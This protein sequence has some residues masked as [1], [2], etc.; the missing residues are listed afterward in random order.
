MTTGHRRALSSALSLAALAGLATAQLWPGLSQDLSP[1]ISWDHGSHLGKAMLTAQELLPW[2]LRGW[3]DLV[4]TGVPLGTLYTPIGTM[5]ILLFRAVTP[6]LEW[7][8]SY[9][10][11]FLGFRVLVG[12]SVYR[13]ARVAGAGHLGATA[14]GV[15]AL[16]D[17]GDHSEG[18]WFYDVL[19]GV[20]PMSIAMCF[21][22]LALAD[23]LVY[24]E[25]GERVVG[26]RAALLL[27]VALFS[28]QM[29]LVAFGLVVPCLVVAR[30]TSGERTSLRTDLS[31]VLPVA[32]VGGAIASWWM[33]PMLSMSRWLEDHG[34]LYRDT[35]DMGA[36]LLGGEGILGAGAWTNVLVALGLAAALV[37]KSA[38]R[39]LALGALVA[40]LVG[41]SGWFLAL[42]ASRYLPAFGRIV[43]PRLMMVSKPMLFALAGVV[44]H[45]LGARVLPVLRAQAR[46]PR[47]RLGLVVAALALAPFL[48]DVPARLSTLLLERDVPTTAT[49]SAWRDFRAAW[50]WV[51][52]RPDGEGF[53]RVA[54][55][56]ESTHLPQAAP[57]YTGRPAH[58]TGPLVG[59]SFRNNTDS[60]HPLALRAMNVRYVVTEGAPGLELA[61]EVDRVATFGGLV[62]SELRGWSGAVA[63]AGEGET[64]VPRTVALERERVVVEPHGARTVVVRR[65]L[66]PGWVATADGTEVP[67]GEERVFDSPRL[68]LMRVEVPAGTERLELRYHGFRAPHWL[69]MLATLVG[70]LVTLLWAGGW[71]RVPAPWRA[72]AAALVTRFGA[73]VP[74]SLERAWPTLACALPFVG[75]AALVLANARGTHLPPR[76]R[77]A[78]GSV[79]HDD[80]TTTPCARR[81]SDGALRCDE[82]VVERTQVAVDGVYRSCLTAPPPRGGTLVLAWDDLLLGGTLRLGGGV[83]D[84]A[85]LRRGAPIEV[86]A[87][88]DGDEVTTFEVPLSHE[89]VERTVPV[90]GGGGTHDVR[91]EVRSDETHRRLFCL[92]A[93][94]R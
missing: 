58:I 26:A 54:Y 83:D 85:F 80:G 40:M 44:L 9:A 34:Q 10:L 53:Y 61:S 91:I 49:T 3:T 7:H 56:S 42:D 77:E 79:L 41:A 24:V 52:D 20:W 19:Y 30:M 2:S 14:A 84:Q 33:L 35:P 23:L 27:G 50:A 47:G 13:L 93:V 81:S 67:I 76:L 32:F 92:D 75:V 22:F 69:G 71:E 68:R 18:G 25:K 31:R 1:P 90:P 73:R 63:V 8:Q 36:R 45:E 62:L 37:G 70:L 60:T 87:L 16:A 51:A 65:A 38:R 82:V 21:F 88:V 12:A 59:E 86:R 5:W 89:W 15:L 57:G 64:A 74:S 72:R 46:A 94:S 29:S 17:I 78:A 66:G 55:F 6:F 39:S 11:A 48:P 4:E 28:H 43:F